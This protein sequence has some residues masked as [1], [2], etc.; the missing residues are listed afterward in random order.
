[1]LITIERFKLMDTYT[2]GR[3]L[4]DGKFFGWTLEDTVRVLEKLEDKIPGK[5]AIPYG[6]YEV[7]VSMSN[8]FKKELPE[9]LNVPYFKGIRIHGGN[10]EAD[11]EGCVLIGANITTDQR[12]INNC[13]RKVDELI[14]RIKK[15][16]AA[17]Q[18]VFIEVKA[19]APTISVR[20]KNLVNS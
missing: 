13:K 6:K 15:A 19:E 8:R 2:M 3:M 9:I 4:I 10:T 14:K 18:K 17:G 7:I 12:G 11:T 20:G 5:T 1:M 16:N